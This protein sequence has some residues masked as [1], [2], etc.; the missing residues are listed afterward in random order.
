VD[1][2]RDVV[3]KLNRETLKA[4]DTPKLRDRF[5]QM[6]LEPMVM[7]PTEFDAYV[8]EEIAL[9]AARVQRIGMK[10]E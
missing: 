6:G 10:P 9:N 4:L 5:A 2:P 1:T 7:T 3:E 8:R